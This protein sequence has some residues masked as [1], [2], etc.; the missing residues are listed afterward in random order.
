M[1]KTATLGSTVESEGAGPVHN[2]LV[3]T[4]DVQLV[5]QHSRVY[6]IEGF[7][8]VLIG[9]VNSFA[10]VNQFG[11]LLYHN[12]KFGKA[13]TSRIKTFVNERSF[14]SPKFA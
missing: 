13:A 12:K 14:V 1:S 5:A 7:C 11:D 10:G 8:E 4:V 9:H 2:G 3:D 6:L